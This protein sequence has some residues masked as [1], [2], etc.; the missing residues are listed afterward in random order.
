MV[1][2]KVLRPNGVST[3]SSWRFG[4]PLSSSTISTAV[5]VF[6]APVIGSFDFTSCW[7][8][9]QAAS[10][11]QPRTSRSRPPSMRYDAADR[12]YRQA[13]DLADADGTPR[14]MVLDIRSRA[15]ALIA[16]G[17]L[18]DAAALVGRVGAWAADDLDCALLRANS[19][20]NARSPRAC[21][22]AAAVQPRLEPRQRDGS[23]TEGDRKAAGI[24]VTDDLSS[25]AR[26]FPRPRPQLRAQ[27]PHSQ[28]GTDP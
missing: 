26:R 9:W 11:R 7:R 25:I 19:P 21:R 27:A 16:R 12:A 14:T 20:A 18:G 4:I 23:L 15:T 3:G 6:S 28:Q 8:V 1:K 22:R 13:P 17:R 10:L 24:D 2:L 5:M